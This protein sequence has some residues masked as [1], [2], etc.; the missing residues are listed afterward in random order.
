MESINY[1]EALLPRVGF[2]KEV[3]MPDIL[4]YHLNDNIPILC[5]QDKRKTESIFPKW[6]CFI[7]NRY[8][9][10]DGIKHFSSIIHGYLGGR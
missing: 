9:L 5:R 6:F 1:L 3:N 8:V 2:Y 4:V 7:C 10:P